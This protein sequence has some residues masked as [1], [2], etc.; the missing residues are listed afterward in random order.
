M[1]VVGQEKRM[2]LV[3]WF[4]GSSRSSRSGSVASAR[5]SR[6]RRLSPTDRLVKSA[7]GSSCIFDSTMSM[8]GG[9]EDRSGTSA[10]AMSRI[11]PPR[12]VGRSCDSRAMRLPGCRVM[13]PPSAHRLPSIIFISVDL[14]APLRPSRQSRSPGSMCRR[15]PSSRGRAPNARAMSCRD[16]RVILAYAKYILLLSVPT[17]SQ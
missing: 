9:P 16:R 6:V 14:P 13:L 17:S 8:T 11:V 12:P 3:R 4:V 7:S 15:R 5:A 2:S 1:N 10:P